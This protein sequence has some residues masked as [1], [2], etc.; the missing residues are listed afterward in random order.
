MI[1]SQI[2]TTSSPKGSYFLRATAACG[3]SRLFMDRPGGRGRTRV[4]KRSSAQAKSLTFAWFG[5]SHRDTRNKNRHG[6]FYYDSWS[7]LA[8]WKE[9][10]FLAPG[11]FVDMEKITQRKTQRRC[12][13]INRDSPRASIFVATKI[14]FP[15]P[16]GQG[17]KNQVLTKDPRR[18][19]LRLDSCGF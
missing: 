2:E 9:S 5:N 4:S 14:I 3:S 6:L 11:T 7:C 1:E 18:C 17:T 16:W 8:V 10:L 12:Q 19:L 15:T 13:G